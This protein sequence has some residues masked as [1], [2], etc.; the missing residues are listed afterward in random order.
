MYK[1]AGKRA[2]SG[3]PIDLVGPSH[4]TPLKQK[5]YIIVQK[6]VPKKTKVRPKK[7]SKAKKKNTNNKKIIN[8]PDWS[9]LDNYISIFN[10]LIGE[11]ILFSL[12]SVGHVFEILKMNEDL[13]IY[14][15]IKFQNIQNG[16]E[17]EKILGLKKVLEMWEDPNAILL[18]KKY[19]KYVKATVIKRAFLNPDTKLKNKIKLSKRFNRLITFQK[20]QFTNTPLREAQEQ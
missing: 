15:K 12:G 14:V 10:Q 16:L 6:P 4:S 5:S 18:L 13:K 20:K 7:K 8:A 1:R 9:E 2:R 17:E 3:K 11:K 19:K